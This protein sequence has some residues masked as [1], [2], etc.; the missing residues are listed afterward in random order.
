[1]RGGGSP[2]GAEDPRLRSVGSDRHRGRAA[3]Q[4]LRRR[5][6]RR[7][8]HEE[9]RARRARSERPRS[10][11]TAGRLH[12]ERRDLRRHLRRRRQALVPAL[13]TLA[14]AGWASTSKPTSA[15]CGTSRSGVVD[16]VDRRQAGGFPMPK[17]TKKDVGFLK[18]LI[19]AGEYRAVVDRSLSAEGRRRSDQVRRDAAEDRKRCPD[20]QR[21]KI[22]CI[23]AAIVP[24][25]RAA[26]ALTMAA[27][28]LECR[29]VESSRRA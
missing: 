11:T 22:R 4:A 17:Y 7:V 26:G 29:S 18:E 15:S 28:T 10:S 1:M 24:S 8:Q 19:E 21:L 13:S 25:L 27:H 6:D 9:P 3:R 20:R 5:R 16:A 14:E 2:G 12:E 23:E